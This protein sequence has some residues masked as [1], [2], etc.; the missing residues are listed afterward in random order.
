MYSSDGLSVSNRGLNAGC[1]GDF[2]ADSTEL[3]S[4]LIVLR[5][6][7]G[8]LFNSETGD[9]LPSFSVSIFFKSDT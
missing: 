1:L 4:L 7:T 3:H 8:D 5:R 9:L 2:F 6:D